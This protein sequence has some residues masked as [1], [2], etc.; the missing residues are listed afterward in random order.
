[1]NRPLLTKL[2]VSNQ[3]CHIFLVQTYQNGK[4]IPKDHKLSNYTKRPLNTYTKGLLHKYTKIFHSQALPNISKLRFLC[5]LKI[6]HL[7][8]LLSKFCLFFGGGVRAAAILR[9]RFPPEAANSC[10]WTKYQIS[11][12]DENGGRRQKEALSWKVRS[13]LAVWPK[14]FSKGDQNFAPKKFEPSF[15]KFAETT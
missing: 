12:E 6:N 7:A 8:T 15:E 5:S 3:G 2:Q 1:M 10:L 13:S 4:S 14:S 9:Q 11:L